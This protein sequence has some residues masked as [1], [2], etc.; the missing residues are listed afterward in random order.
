MYTFVYKN[1]FDVFLLWLEAT[2][3]S[4]KLILDKN[5]FHPK[6]LLIFLKA[7]YFAPTW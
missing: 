2:T 6:C 7:L 3:N 1:N 5:Y 4:L